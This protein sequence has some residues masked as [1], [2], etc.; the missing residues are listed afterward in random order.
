LSLAH[1]LDSARSAPRSARRELTLASPQKSASSASQPQALLPLEAAPAD[2]VDSAQIA[3][4]TR[5]SIV[6][7]NI[8]VE[9]NA[10]LNVP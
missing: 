9:V 6:L 4:Q 7:L 8:K 5:P 10:K 3:S 2:N 1:L